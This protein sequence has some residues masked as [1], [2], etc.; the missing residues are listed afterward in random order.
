M[1]MILKTG[2]F[3]QSLLLVLLVLKQTS[4]FPLV[5][6]TVV[7]GVKDN[8]TEKCFLHVTV[9]FAAVRGD[10]N[11]VKQADNLV[12]SLHSILVMSVQDSALCI[13]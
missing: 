13:I 12:L 1:F 7:K 10:F 3:F 2:V 6:A 4:D 5:V 9:S 8:R 11:S